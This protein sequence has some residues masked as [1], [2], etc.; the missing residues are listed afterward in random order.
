MNTNHDVQHLPDAVKV[1]IGE[2]IVYPKV[3]G[4]GNFSTIY[5][6]SHQILDKRV[7]VK[8]LDSSPNE[9]VRR[10]IELHQLLVHP[11]IVSMYAYHID[12]INSCIYIFMEHCPI[13]DF[14]TFQKHRPMM[15][16]SINKYM[17]QLASGLEYIHQRGIFHRDLKPHNILLDSEHNLK[18]SDF[19]LSKNEIDEATALHRT[20]CGSPLYMAPEILFHSSYD[21]KSDLWSVGV[22]LFEWI[23]GKHPYKSKNLHDLMKNIRTEYYPMP[24]KLLGIGPNSTLI[25][26]LNSLLVK[27]PLKRITWSEFFNNMWIQRNIELEI[28][29][30]LLEFTPGVDIVPTLHGIQTKRFIFLEDYEKHRNT[31]SNLHDKWSEEQSITPARGSQDLVPHKEPNHLALE[32]F[33]FTYH[34]KSNI[35]NTVIHKKTTVASTELLNGSYTDP[36]ADFDG[37]GIID[38][39][40]GGHATS[41]PQKGTR[42][43]AWAWGP[44]D[45][46][47]P[48]G[49]RYT[50]YSSSDDSDNNDEDNSIKRDIQ[51]AIIT[52][53]STKKYIQIV[54]PRR[55]TLN[56]SLASPAFR[57]KTIDEIRQRSNLY[58]NTPPSGS[59]FSHS[60]KSFMYNILTSIGG[61][62]TD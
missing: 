58:N 28:E 10:E 25:E 53:E 40:T 39:G 27:D 44:C 37:I 61:G 21:N 18:I 22:I 11:N 33:G 38:R 20:Y 42:S 1:F 19:G 54:N 56:T 8:K 7:A 14:Y 32:T 30:G 49:C 55:K 35:S 57:D 9:Y 43:G 60:L 17:R 62:K 15:E 59:S 46:A 2:Y 50:R 41:D 29:N 12:H 24:A 31:L 36:L 52:V 26:L 23:T 3:I 45:L 51:D 4:R 5:E 6:G 34:M 48:T 47:V 13:G 16:W